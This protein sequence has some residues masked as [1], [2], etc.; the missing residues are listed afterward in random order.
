MEKE[1][2]HFSQFVAE[3]FTAYSKRKRRDKVYGNNLE[4]QAMSEIY[5]RPIHIYSYST[6]PI[7]I[8][9]GSYGTD[10]PPI[11]FSYHRGNH[12]NSLVDP[13]RLTIGAGLGF[14]SLQG[15]N[16]DKDQVKA[17]IK[18]QQ[19]QQIENALLA[20]GRIYSDLE[21]TETE[22]KRYGPEVDVWTAGV[23]LYILLSGVPPFG[24]KH[25]REFSMLF[26]EVILI[27]IQNPSSQFL[28]VPRILSERCLLQN[29]LSA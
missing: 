21:S 1:R 16:I 9:H 2:D 14:S 10:S 4:I 20:E 24:R 13:H 8:F 6:E 22:N 5:N 19:D 29:H 17:T 18:A 3:I 7:N 12:Y 26:Y 28:R 11:R 25:N 27:L 23:I 15:K